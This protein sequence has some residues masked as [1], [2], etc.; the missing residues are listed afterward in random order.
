MFMCN[1]LSWNF[2]TSFCS[3]DVFRNAIYVLDGAS[4]FLLFS[5]KLPFRCLRG[6]KYLCAKGDL[7]WF[8]LTI[9]I[10]TFYS[11]N[12]FFSVFKY[13]GYNIF[14]VNKCILLWRCSL[15]SENKILVLI[16]FDIVWFHSHSIKL[17]VILFILKF[18]FSP[19]ISW[20]LDW[21]WGFVNN[22]TVIGFGRDIAISWRNLIRDEKKRFSKTRRL[23]AM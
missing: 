21:F 23:R 9:T 18:R 12:N 19:K 11:L 4:A 15:E 22:L 7:T 10:V 17:L 14:N 6:S 16:K 8:V 1:R 13:F 2:S 20:N 5:Q 3:I